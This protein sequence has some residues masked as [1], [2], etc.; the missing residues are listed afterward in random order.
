MTTKGDGAIRSRPGATGRLKLGELL[1]REGLVTKQ[2]LDTALVATAAS[3]KRLGQVLVQSGLIDEDNLARL[4]SRQLGIPF[5]DLER[6]TWQE[7]LTRR[8]PEAVAR[9]HRAVVLQR[10]AYGFLVGLADPLDAGALDE[11]ER[12]LNRSVS[13]AVCPERQIVTALDRIY[14]HGVETAPAG[15]DIAPTAAKASNRAADEAPALPQLQSLFQDAVQLRASDI[16]LDPHDRVLR[17][18]FRID[19][20]LRRQG[21]ADARV[22]GALAQRLKVMAGLDTAEP[23]LPLDG[24]F[25]VK[26][27]DAEIA[28]RMWTLPGQHGDSIVLRLLGD[29]RKVPGLD[30]IGMAADMAAR[31]RAIVQAGRGMVLVAGPARAGKT[32][33][34]YA[35]LAEVDA[36]ARK[37]VAVE[38]TAV[39]RLPGVVQV[40]VE[41]LHLDF[42]GTLR[43]SL[44]QDPDVV[45]VDEIRERE[46]VAVALRAGVGALVLAGMPARDAHAAIAR[47][48]DMGAPMDVVATCLHAVIA[49]GSCRLN[50]PACGREHAATAQERG[51]L[52]LAGG[53]KGART[54]V[55]HGAGCAQCGGTGYQGRST[56][57][58]MLAMDDKLVDAALGG[59]AT[60]LLALVRE[61]LRGQAL[62]DHALALVRAGRTSPAEA[63]R[64]TS[65]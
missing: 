35:A 31:L 28:V 17:I 56:F 33:T 4:L 49:Q 9:R 16:H 44:Q 27:G 6:D 63:M 40:Q 12:V 14:R 5:V 19:G 37:V 36:V 53:E 24:R 54:P 7:D 58:E 26:V 61:R 20:V 3:G 18:R 13:P 8:L 25:T 34:L 51:W 2:A 22:A 59:G 41:D 23:R 55:R 50:C 21:E 10:Q 30:A 57:Y 29:S 39:Y 62:A 45:L 11:I 42:V 47:L 38:D 65:A 1:L 64:A 52:K 32:T 43:A 46:S 60:Q 48:A 15:K